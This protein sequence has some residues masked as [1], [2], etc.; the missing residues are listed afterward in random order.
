MKAAIFHSPRNITT[1]EVEMPTISAKDILIKVKSCCICGSDLH[2]YKLG[3]Y[4]DIITRK[5]DRGGI[6]G[7]EFS[8][9]IVD[10]GSEVKDLAVGDRVSAYTNGG[11]AEYVPLSPVFPGRNEFK[12]PD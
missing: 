11:M 12:I 2:M 7:H 10:V 5:T 6:P 1:E 8:G 3:L 4:A 9:E